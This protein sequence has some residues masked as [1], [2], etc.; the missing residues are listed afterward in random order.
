VT[1]PRTRDEIYIYLQRLFFEYLN[2]PSEMG[3]DVDG[4]IWRA[5]NEL[6]EEEKKPIA[7][8]AA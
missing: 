6:A 3:T 4:I 7:Q 8:T 2:P 5:A 1:K